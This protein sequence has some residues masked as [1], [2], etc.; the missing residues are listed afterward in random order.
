MGVREQREFIQ[1]SLS[2]NANVKPEPQ[3]GCK[4][5][6][7]FEWE[8]LLLNYTSSVLFFIMRLMYSTLAN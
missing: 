2:S 6:S 3:L 7:A 1:Q 4:E 5:V 8:Q